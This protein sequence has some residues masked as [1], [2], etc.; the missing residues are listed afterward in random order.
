MTDKN[1]VKN[2]LGNQYTVEKKNTTR[3]LQTI[4]AINTQII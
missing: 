4:F 1:N 3:Q 2:G